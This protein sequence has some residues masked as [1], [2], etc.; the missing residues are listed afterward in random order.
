MQ[1]AEITNIALEKLEISEDNTRKINVEKGLDVLANSI[2]ELGVIDPIIVAPKGKDMY[3][4]VEGQRRVLASKRIGLREIPAIIKENLVG[5]HTR[6]LTISLTSNLQR[7]SIDPIDRAKYCKELATILP[8]GYKDV[9]KMLGYGENTIRSWIGVDALPDSLKNAVKQGD[10]SVNSA[11]HLFGAYWGDEKKI[12]DI[13][14][15]MPPAPLGEKKKLVKR[16]VEEADKN[17]DKPAADIIADA[18]KPPKRK[19]KITV[20]LPERVMNGIEKA[21]DLGDT[22]EDRVENILYE[23]LASKN[24]L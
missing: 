18:K 21:N 9:A 16:I 20:I 3:E 11:M 12:N 22:V 14:E 1:S 19:L 17:P 7:E 24:L 23:Y 15:K 8:D 10:V 5:D 2:K 4:V 13:I 6:K